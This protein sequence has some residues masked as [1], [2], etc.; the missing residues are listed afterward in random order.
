MAVAQEAVA[1]EM[2]NIRQPLVAT[3]HE[4]VAHHEIAP[5]E[6]PNA[7]AVLVWSDLTVCTKRGNKVLLN[8]V[9]VM[10]KKLLIAAHGIKDAFGKGQIYF[11]S[12]Y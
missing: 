6:P 12:H 11:M 1:I 8:K 4:T 10:A 2:E 3:V 7:P 5:E 9:S